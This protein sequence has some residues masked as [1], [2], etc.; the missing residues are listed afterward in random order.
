LLERVASSGDERLLTWDSFN[1]VKQR[2]PLLRPKLVMLE[3]AETL[4]DLAK[5][6]GN[7]REALKKDR[8]GQYS[9]RMNDQWR[10]CFVLLGKDANAVEIVDYH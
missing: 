2:E 3:D 9:I 4:N 6:P 1:Q 10:V 8:A 5:L 7:R